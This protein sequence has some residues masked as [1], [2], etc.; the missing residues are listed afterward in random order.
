LLLLLGAATTVS[1]A[2]H[3]DITGMAYDL[4]YGYSGDSDLG[5]VAP[6]DGLVEYI[7]FTDAMFT[8][9]DGYA[10]QDN[11]VE[12]KDTSEDE[13]ETATETEAEDK[14]ESKPA[15]LTSAQIRDAR[16]SVRATNSRVL[17]SVT[18]NNRESRIEVKFLE[19][20]VGTQEQEFDFDV[21][22]SIDGRQQ[23]DYAMN[24]SGTLA[25]LTIQADDNTDYADISDG[26]VVEA[27]DYIRAITLDLGDGVELSTRLSEGRKYYGTAERVPYD[28]RDQFMDEYPSVE[29]AIVLKTV[30]LSGS[31]STVTLGEGL[32][33]YYVYSEDGEYLGRGNDKLAYSDVY[34][35][36]SKKL[37]LAEDDKPEDATKPTD[38]AANTEP[39]DPT[40]S[41]PGTAP[42]GS[43]P[44]SPP[45][46]N[47]NP[48]TGGWADMTP[49]NVNS[50][51]GTGR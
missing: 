4:S 25:N 12:D 8:W 40:S 43:V 10:P 33:S 14:N 44:M 31:A 17:E 36:S 15:P 21:I 23:R 20:L 19:E 48:G 27:M 49:P 28:D 26:E 7:E 11:V 1:A 6:Q 41:A 46:A 30:G 38:P 47:N 45:N 16:L 39:T 2:D 35:L 9:E 51:P 3:G 34:Y 13:G 24:F 32:D 37:D 5:E 29:E 18:V 50:I 22:L 42:S